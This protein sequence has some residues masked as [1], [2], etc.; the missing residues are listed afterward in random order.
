MDFFHIRA[1]GKF[2]LAFHARPQSFAARAHGAVVQIC[3]RLKIIRMNGERAYSF[4]RFIRAY[5]KFYRA[6]H[7]RPQSFAARAHGAVCKFAVGVLIN[8]A[9]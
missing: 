8:S 7:A 3:R 6:F 2:Y 1:Y 9:T 4:C 5:G